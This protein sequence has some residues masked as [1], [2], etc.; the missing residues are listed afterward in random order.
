MEKETSSVED[1][2]TEINELEAKVERANTVS[3]WLRKGG[4]P[5]HA[6]F[7]KIILIFVVVLFLVLV[8]KFYG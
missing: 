5:I 3:P 1:L 8:W 4:K 6:E 7:W 2:N